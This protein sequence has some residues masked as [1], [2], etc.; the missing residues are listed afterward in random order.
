MKAVLA[1]VAAVNAAQV[2]EKAVTKKCLALT[3][4]GGGTK[5]AYEAGALWGMY[6]ALADKT[7]M[8]YDVVTGVSAG[9]I[10]TMVV[11]MYPKGQEK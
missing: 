11:A 10:N 8:Q 4:S 3:M 6:Y 7:Q 5:G 9:S 1:A 2:E